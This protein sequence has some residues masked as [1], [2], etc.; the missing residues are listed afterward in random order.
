MRQ[1]QGCQDIERFSPGELFSEGVRYGG[2]LFL[3]GQVAHQR[4][5]APFEAQL[6]EVLSHVHSLLEAGNSS[7]DR[8]LTALIHVAATD[9]VEALNRI[10]GEWLPRGASPARTTVISPLVAPQ[11]LV[12]ITITAAVLKSSEAATDG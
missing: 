6:G 11:Y 8:L 10:W 4:P 12:E 9:H 1:A 5:D 3:S 2:V 7:R